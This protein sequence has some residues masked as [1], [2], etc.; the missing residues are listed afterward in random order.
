MVTCRYAAVMLRFER[1]VVVAALG[2]L[3]A[4]V[5]AWCAALW[6]TVHVVATAPLRPLA[7][8]LPPPPP[9]EWPG[10]VPPDWGAPK[11]V[12]VGTGPALRVGVGYSRTDG[13]TVIEA[14]WP[15]RALRATE[16]A[17]KMTADARKVSYAGGVALARMVELKLQWH[18]DYSRTP[19]TPSG[20]PAI[21][22][23][24]TETRT[25]FRRLPLEPLWPG[26]LV[27][28]ALYAGVVAVGF[29]GFT[30]LRGRARR[31]RGRCIACGYPVGSGGRCPECGLAAG[32]LAPDSRAAVVP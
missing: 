4:F 17:P 11:F 8:D 20:T 6:G 25:P 23:M 18:E 29:L 3:I 27:D 5:V 21:L 22:G 1:A 15:M 2:V 30:T 26:L 31:R 12:V 14:G 13:T 24:V 28:S 9:L 16:L 19:G 7:V 10:R 32:T